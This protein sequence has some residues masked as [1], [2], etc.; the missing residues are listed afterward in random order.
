MFSD[1]VTHENLPQAVEYLINQI[2]RLEEKFGQNSAE[3]SEES[4]SYF[5]VDEL[6]EYLPQRPAK[7]TIYGWTSN[8]I[9]PYH[10]KGKNIYFLKSEIDA[11]LLGEGR[12]S[13]SEIALEAQRYVSSKTERRRG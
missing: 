13:T 8:R 6:S 10:K 2:E 4:E 9:I 5:S 7:Q 1:K 11:W 12:K 3:P